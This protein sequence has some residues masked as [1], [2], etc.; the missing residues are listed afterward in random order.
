MSDAMD[1][2]AKLIA[3]AD[4]AEGTP[5]GDLAK[6]RAIDMSAEINVELAVARAHVAKKEAREEPVAGQV[7]RVNAHGGRPIHRQ[8]MM[9]LWLA[10]ADGHE[11]RCTIG[12]E[13]FY[14]F[15]YGF[16][17]DIEIAEKLFAALSLQMI[18]EA[19]VAIKNGEQKWVLDTVHRKIGLDARIYRRNF[20]EG[21][22]RRVAGRLWNARTA[23]VKATDAATGGSATVALRDKSIEVDA[24]Y[25]KETEHL[26]LRGSYK[27]L[28]NSDSRVDD[29]IRAGNRAGDRANLGADNDLAASGKR[30]LG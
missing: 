7:I 23:A 26:S 13:N 20:Y 8:A 2:L 27:G 11:I 14:A 17:S 15:A 22:T 10:I 29:A 9:D 25:E 19:D 1:R 21:F 12:S 30:E 3:L 6:Q 28:D 18:T 5:E 24:F 16:P 4:R